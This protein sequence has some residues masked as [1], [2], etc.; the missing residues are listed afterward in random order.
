MV[1]QDPSR[2]KVTVGRNIRT[3]RDLHN[4]SQHDLAVRLDCHAM[5]VSK[6]ERGLHSPSR[7][8]LQALSEALGRPVGWF[9][10]DHDKAAA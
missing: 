7:H 8:N 4:L 10:T 1:S 3:A 5:L 2:I 6:W 9:Y